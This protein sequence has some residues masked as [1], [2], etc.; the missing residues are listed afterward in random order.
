MTMIILDERARFQNLSRVFEPLVHVLLQQQEE[1]Q[2]NTASSFRSCISSALLFGFF[3]EAFV[4]KMGLKLPQTPQRSLAGCS[5]R[6]P[7]RA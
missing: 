1:E 3:G 4:N 6:V 7:S 5:C 2:H